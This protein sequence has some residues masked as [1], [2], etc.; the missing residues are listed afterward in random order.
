[1]KRQ[2][3]LPTRYFLCVFLPLSQLPCVRAHMDG[4][5]TSTCYNSN[6]NSCS[7]TSLVMESNYKIK[8][9]SLEFSSRHP[10]ACSVACT[11]GQ[12]PPRLPTMGSGRVVRGCQT[13]CQGLTEVPQL[14]SVGTE[15]WSPQSND[16]FHPRL[17]PLVGVLD[18]LRGS[19]PSGLR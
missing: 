4:L 19:W 11:R 6:L 13:A 9:S 14:V 2:I 7:S 16:T 3:G 15:R 10:L 5:Y 1:M 12:S 18:R 17:T 8:V